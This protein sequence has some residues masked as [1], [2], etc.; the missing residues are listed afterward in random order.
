V[1]S[2]ALGPLERHVQKQE[3]AML[4]KRNLVF[5]LGLSCAA[6]VAVI[7]VCRDRMQMTSHR[8]H[9]KALQ[10]WESEGGNVMPPTMPG[11]AQPLPPDPAG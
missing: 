8:S 7:K 9:R 6:V 5:A 2:N 1:R 3:I 10:R 4:N 11:K